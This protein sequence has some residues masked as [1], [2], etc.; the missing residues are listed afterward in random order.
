MG[1][2]SDLFSGGG[3]LFQWSTVSSGSFTTPIAGKYRITLIGVGSGASVS[4][5]GSSGAIAQSLVSLPA[6]TVITST[7]GAPGTGHNTTPVTGGNSTVS[8]TGM[9]TLSCTAGSPLSPGVASGGNVFNRNGVAGTTAPNRGGSSV[10]V[11]GTGY[12]AT[13]LGGAGVG[14]SAP[15]SGMHYIGGAAIRGITN[16]SIFIG[17]RLLQPAGVG[18]TNGVATTTSSADACGRPGGGGGALDG[19][20][21][22]TGMRGGMFAGGGSGTSG[23]SPGGAGGVGGGGGGTGNGTGAGG[24]GGEAMTIIEWME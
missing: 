9:T 13:G 4:Q 11:Y 3:A 19:G 24:N 8:A 22:G 1:G 23:N 16:S 12:A 14:E 18:G 10:A 15:L 2:F 21:G 5:A 7:H 6:G 17:G 20:S